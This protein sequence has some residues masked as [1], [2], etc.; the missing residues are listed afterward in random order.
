MDDTAN[1]LV[2]VAA[3]FRIHDWGLF[4]QGKNQGRAGA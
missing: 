3:K 1:Q 4:F 2:A